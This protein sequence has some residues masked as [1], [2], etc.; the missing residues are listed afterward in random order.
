MPFR[1]D[2]GTGWIY[3]TK[4]LD[5]EEKDRYLLHYMASADLGRTSLAT[6]VN[7]TIRLGDEND[8]RPTFSQSY[9]STVVTSHELGMSV[10][11][12]QAI[13]KDDGENGRVTYGI[14]K[15][16]DKHYFTIHSRTGELKTRE[17]LPATSLLAL[18]IYISA[19]D[20]GTPLLF[21]SKPVPV[22]VFIGSTFPITVE[23]VK[24][25]TSTIKLRFTMINVSL[26]DI[27][28]IGV[29][30]QGVENITDCKFLHTF[31][32]GCDGQAL[33][34]HSPTELQLLSIFTKTGLNFPDFSGTLF[35]VVP[36][37][38]RP[39]RGFFATLL[40]LGPSDLDRER[41]F[42]TE[43]GKASQSLATRVPGRGTEDIQA[44]SGGIADV[45]SKNMESL[46]ERGEK[47]GELED[48]TRQMRDQ[49]EQYSRNAHALAQRFKDKKW[50][51]L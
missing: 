50:Y 46:N 51:Q 11:T 35:T 9:Y 4:R 45:M 37:P 38:E 41:L 8:N 17:H 1:V 25:T 29:V 26:A 42:G 12:V 24:R 28:H 15:G 47:L 5:R 40:N 3:T 19:N 36:V 33:Y 22:F 23:T 44:R 30:M 39:N 27:S 43:S 13:D 48:R 31:K 49:A 7:V 32:F 34:L 18:K 10:L 2:P 14:V 20:H 21:S 6:M 16:Q